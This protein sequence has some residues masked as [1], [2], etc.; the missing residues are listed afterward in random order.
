MLLSLNVEAR[1]TKDPKNFSQ[2]KNLA[3][4]LY[5]D[6]KKSYFLN[7]SYH[8]DKTSCL[9]KTVVDDNCSDVEAKKVVYKRIITASFFAK[10]RTCMN[11]KI[12]TNMRGVKYKGERCCRKSD[13]FYQK[14][15][16]DIFNIAPIVD[17]YKGEITPQ[18]R[19]DVARVYLYY[20]AH[21]G[22]KLSE[23]EQLKYFKWHQ[24]DKPDKSEC[25]LYR[26]VKKIQKNSNIFLE[27]SCP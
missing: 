15:D 25:S 26:T 9:L 8:Y 14:M 20:N 2:A 7:C 12:C 5:F 17:S 22:M 4:A 18:K 6:N 10:D 1:I 11:E 27:K 23:K 13:D 16:S 19:G 3:R 21:Y 24:E